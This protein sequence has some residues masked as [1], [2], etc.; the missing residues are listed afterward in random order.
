MR[1]TAHCWSGAP[2]P[3]ESPSGEADVGA[4]AAAGQR[5][6]ARKRTRRDPGNYRKPR[7]YHRVCACARASLFDARD[8]A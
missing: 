6:R 5:E 3:A 4:A 8:C 1:H 7:G 2:P